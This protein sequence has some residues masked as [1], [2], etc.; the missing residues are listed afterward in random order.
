MFLSTPGGDLT[1]AALS[2]R[3]P[4]SSEG[5]VAIIEPQ[6][7]LASVVELFT[8]LVRG[9]V[10]LG[11]RGKSSPDSPLA[12]GVVT[13]IFTSGT[14]GEPKGVQLT[15][16]NWRA[17]V[18][19]SSAHLD[20]R[21]DDVWLTAM[22]LDHVG[23]ISVLFRSAHV[24]GTVR[25][26]PSFDARSFADELGGGVTMAS[27]VPT[28][29]RR[30]LDLDGRTYHG[31]KAVLVGGG[32]IPV[33]LLEAAWGRGIPAL[34]TYGMTETC[35]QVATLRPGSPLG[36]RADLLPGVEARIELDGRIALRGRQ[37]FAG[38]LGGPVRRPGDWFLTSDLGRLEGQSLVILGRA[39]SV[40][41]TGGENVDPIE[42]E[43]IVDAHPDVARSMVVG[44]PSAEWGNELVCLY[45]GTASP[46]EL[47][48]W[49]ADSEAL[50]R[51]KVPKRWI[52][53]GAVP[54]TE[55]GKPDRDR[56]RRIAAD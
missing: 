21:S 49:V 36:Y 50:D 1:Y 19:A 41:V 5:G 25:M 53:V 48:T 39:D 14:T 8:G 56:G 40:I 15:A 4:A 34:P 55:L 27:M 7:D 13:V 12:A 28:M 29:L 9:A 18:E 11:S 20:H 51:F 47:E 17:A 10:V 46:S 42:V 30:V 38:Y 32:P 31:L 24:G 37:L 33:G 44:V 2:S 23:G 45:E 22:P 54:E 3:L 26:L 35:A 6:R 52:R 16:D 43:R